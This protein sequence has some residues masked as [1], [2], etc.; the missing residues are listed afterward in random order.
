[1]NTINVKRQNIFI[2]LLILLL[3]SATG[4]MLEISLSRLYSYMLS[5][6]FVFI[7]IAFTLFGLGVGEMAYYL[8]KWVQQ[9]ASWFYNTLPVTILFSFVLMVSMNKSDIFSDTSFLLLANIILSVISFIAIGI[10]KAD[11]FY[12]NRTN[13]TWFYS[14]DLIGSAGGALL[15]VFVMNNLGLQETFLIG[16]ILLA[17]VAVSSWLLFP[18]PKTKIFKRAAWILLIIVL[19]WASFGI[20]NFNPS[21]S[22]DNNKDMLRI[23]SNPAVKS[24][25]IETE[26]NSFGKTDLIELTSPDGTSEKVMFVDGAAGTDLVS[27]DELEGNL[28]QHA[29][30]LGHFPAAFELNFLKENEKDSVLII[31]PGGGVDIAAA[32]LMGFG[33]IDAAEIN[34]SFVRL[35]KKYNPS[36]FTEKENIAVYVN[37]GRNFVRQTSNR[38]DVIMLTIPVTKGGRGADFYGLSENYLFT[39]EAIKDYRNALTPEGRLV[40]TMHSPTEVYRMLSN[41]LQLA[42]NEG[43]DGKSAMQHVL[44]YSNGMMPVMVIKKAPFEKEETEIKHALA[45]QFNFD[46]ATFFMPNVQQVKGD[47]LVENKN[48]QWYMFDQLIYG[49]SQNEFN[50]QQISEAA[51][52]NLEPVSDESPYFFNYENGIPK[53]LTNL[54]ILS[55][56][57]MGWVIYK[58]ARGWKFRQEIEQATRKKLNFLAFV[59]FV[60]G[61]GYFFVQSY[62]F[63]ILNLQLSN[64][65]QS[66]S[67]LLFTFLL[68]NSL[69]SLVTGLFRKNFLLK[70]GVYSLIVA[71]VMI[72]VSIFVVPG[73]AGSEVPQSFMIVILLIPAFFVGIPFPSLLKEVSGEQEY[74]LPLF[75][76]ISSLVSMA[77]AVMVIV[78]SMLW[79]YSCVL[80]L[81]VTGY[82]VVAVSLVMFYR[83]NLKIAKDA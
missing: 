76:G 67:L 57:I 48:Y 33:Q 82:L 4:I 32:W 46:R 56:I 74:I 18:Y 73:F 24:R 21:I 64:P 77:T 9:K 34:P 75:L 36:T 28:E 81:G 42:E 7:I 79:G 60:L 80:W 25:I 29:H 47:T 59:V 44:I 58:T 78:V 69:G 43:T 51:L 27:I 17:I 39:R 49:I 37:E 61:I 50:Y 54:F 66:F 3:V 45:H 55:L 14:S 70:A 13:V 6:H 53:S 52:L 10:V 15:T 23:M 8:I 30:K 68:G 1:M 35:M 41:Y 31:G 5:Y 63:Q 72:A 22:K 26:W 2:G 83:N 12:S 65:A 38:Y 71:L 20:Y 62:L 19:G 11:I 16:Y 40:L